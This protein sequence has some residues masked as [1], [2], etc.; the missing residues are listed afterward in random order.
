MHYRD[1]RPRH[2]CGVSSLPNV[3][4]DN[5]TS[6]SSIHGSSDSLKEI[7]VSVYTWAAQGQHRYKACADYVLE[8]LAITSV[9]GLYDVSPVFSRH[10][11]CSSYCICRVRVF[12]R[13]KAIWQGFGHDRK[14][15]PMGLCCQM[16]KIDCRA[17]T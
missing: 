9:E 15:P 17:M 4:P 3:A 8:A 2:R 1:Q 12:M 13:L 11:T 14:V 5:N 16:R 7:L 10:T 6:R